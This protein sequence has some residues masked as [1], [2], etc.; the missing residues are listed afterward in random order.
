MA[1][2][3]KCSNTNCKAKE[4]C[5]RFVATA[6]VDQLYFNYKPNKNSVKIE[7]DFR[8]EI[9]KLPYLVKNRPDSVAQDMH[10][11]ESYAKVEERKARK[12]SPI[13]RSDYHDTYKYRESFLIREAR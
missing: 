12:H 13:L 1:Q 6:S 4:T 9:E 7:C 5:Y 10:R 2:I 11:S 3:T 8:I